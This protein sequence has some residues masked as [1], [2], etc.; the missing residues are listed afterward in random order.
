MGAV[1]DRAGVKRDRFARLWRV[2]RI[3]EAHPDGMRAEEVARVAGVSKRTAYRDL[4]AVEAE[5]GVPVWND[6]GRWGI[7]ERAFLPTLSLTLQEA[8]VVFLAARLMAASIDTYDPDLTGAFLKLGDIVPPAIREHVEHTLDILARR[9]PD[10]AAT[11]R[12]HDLVR[13]WAERRIV[14]LTYDAGTYDPARP[15]R[16]VRVHPWLI[17]PSAHA[18]ALYL[19]G[20]DEEREARRT[21]KVDRVRDVR[22]T[23]ETFEPP[24]SGATE[25]SLERAWWIIADQG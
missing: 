20:W 10:P 21:F 11:R 4:L 19:I 5:A 16:T 23:P 15:P 3:L 25:E 22:L 24:T 1:G 6:R 2:V 14:E 18:H 7:D 13:A 8:M 17:E 12:L 9:H